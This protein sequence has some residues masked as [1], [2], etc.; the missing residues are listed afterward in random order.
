LTILSPDYSV[1]KLAESGFAN[2]FIND[3]RFTA[4]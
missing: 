1:K 3:F 2:D 4:L